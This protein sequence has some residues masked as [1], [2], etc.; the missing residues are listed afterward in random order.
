MTVEALN[1]TIILEDG[2]VLGYAE[3]GNSKG[4]PLFLLHGLNSS[5]LEVNIVHKK[6]KNEV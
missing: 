2:R 4:K 1:K 5:R 3:A 6:W